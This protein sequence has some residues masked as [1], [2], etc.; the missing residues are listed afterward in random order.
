ML[1][2]FDLPPTVS[3]PLPDRLPALRGA[4]EGSEDGVPRVQATH[5]GC[6][7]ELHL[8]IAQHLP[9]IVS[10]RCCHRKLHLVID[11]HKGILMRGLLAVYR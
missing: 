6:H 4:A 7:R 2:L 10:Y 9:S 8:M 11:Q 3:Q 5:P 1:L